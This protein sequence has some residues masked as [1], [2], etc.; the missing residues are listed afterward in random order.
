MTL[1]SLSYAL[2]GLALAA[3]RTGYA[4][5][6]VFEDTPLGAFSSSPGS[7]YPALRKLTASGHLDART[8]GN[9]AIYHVTAKGRRVLRD[10]ALAPVTLHEISREADIA[11]LRFAFQEMLGDA[12]GTRAFLLSF[13]EAVTAHIA[14]LEAYMESDDVIHMSV[15]GRLAMEN[16]IM[17]YRCNLAWA[18]KALRAFPEEGK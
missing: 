12:A 6:K 7:I 2:I 18:E 9:S 1:T 14:G 17:S 15:H 8:D 11:L 16:G 4:L 10:W 3:P 5:R 13:R